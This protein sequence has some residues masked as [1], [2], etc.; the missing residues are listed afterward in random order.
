MEESANQAKAKFEEANKKVEEVKRGWSLIGHNMKKEKQE[1]ADIILTDVNSPNVHKR[2][3]Y[4]TLVKELL[5]KQS[6]QA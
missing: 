4:A 5:R 1:L 2:E 3:I 6:E